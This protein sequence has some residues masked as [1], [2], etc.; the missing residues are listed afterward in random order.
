LILT[1]VGAGIHHNPSPGAADQKFAGGC[2]DL[3]YL[4][5]ATGCG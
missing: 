3:A 2:D 1:P 5:K 4:Y